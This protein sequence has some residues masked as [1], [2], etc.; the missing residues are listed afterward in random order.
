[1]SGLQV[2]SLILGSLLT[3]F[4]VA[5]IFGSGKYGAMVE[6]LDSGEFPL[7]SLYCIGFSLSNIKI[8]KLRGELRTKLVRQAMLLYDAQ[9]A[10]YYANVVWA[11]VLVFAHLGITLGFLLA[12]LFSS[13]LMLVVGLA[14]AGVFGFYFLNRMGGLLKTRETECTAELP[15]IVSTMALLTHAGMMLRDAWRMIADSKEGTVYTLMR[16]SCVDIDNGMS[17][18]D[19]ILK[20]GKLTNS[21]DVRKFTSALAQ[22]LERGGSELSDFLGRQSNEMWTLKKQLMLQKGEA[23]ASKLLLPTG[24]LFIAIII[25]V[26]CGALGMIF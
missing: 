6:N 20:F 11:Q 12:G 24:M 19:A 8:Y 3:V 26:I 9:Y 16:Q 1:M 22:S 25:A 4:M 15:E 14:I 23:A 7:K 2:L 10:E 5:M 13:A 21:Q 18:V 17:D